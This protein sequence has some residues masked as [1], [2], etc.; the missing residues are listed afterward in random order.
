[1]ALENKTVNE[2]HFEE[3][4]NRR[5][6]QNKSTSYSYHHQVEVAT[7]IGKFERD[8][9]VLLGLAFRHRPF[10]VQHVVAVRPCQ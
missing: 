2:V 8:K 1:M 3:I 7:Y 6:K 5:H 9:P 4:L 10:C